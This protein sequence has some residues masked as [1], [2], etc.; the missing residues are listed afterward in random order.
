[1][2]SVI[3]LLLFLF[4]YILIATAGNFVH[5]NSTIFFCNNG[6]TAAICCFE[7][8]FESLVIFELNSSRNCPLN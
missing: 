7:F 2:V 5:F 6:N 8:R 3:K 1:M 4:P